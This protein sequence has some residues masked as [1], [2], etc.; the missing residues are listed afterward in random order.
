MAQIKFRVRDRYTKKIVGYECQMPDISNDA[1]AWAKSFGGVDWENGVYNEDY[2][3][4]EQFTGLNDKKRNP[5]YEGDIL[6]GFEGEG[7]FIRHGAVYFDQ[8]RFMVKLKGVPRHL[9]T[10]APTYEI[11]A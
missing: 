1:W 6:T 10:L 8:G 3:I 5:I 7:A 2:F 11:E 9:K 4:R